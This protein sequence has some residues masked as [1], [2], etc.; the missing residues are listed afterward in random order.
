MGCAAEG[1]D[2]YAVRQVGS[3]DALLLAAKRR[4]MLANGMKKKKMRD[5]RYA[6]GSDKRVVMEGEVGREKG[7][8]GI[9]PDFGE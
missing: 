3:I 8:S 5:S 2:F 7:A 9:R 4:Q 6:S 1:Q